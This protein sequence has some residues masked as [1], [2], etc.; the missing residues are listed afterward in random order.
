MKYLNNTLRHEFKYIIH[1]R[2]YV[3]LK[4]RLSTMMHPDENSGEEG[5]HIRS[6]Y[7]DDI[8]HTAYFEKLSGVQYRQKYRVRIYNLSDE[9]IKLERKEKF[10]DFI[11]K[12]SINLSKE[13]FYWLI[14]KENLEFLLQK[15]SDMAKDMFW[16][17][18]TKLLAPAVIVD[19]VREVYVMDEGNVRITFDQHLQAGIDTSN[20][21]DRNVTLINVLEPNTMV[22][23]VKYD[24]Y[25][26]AFIQAAIQ[27]PV[28]RREAVSKYIYCRYA[29]FQ[30]NPA[31]QYLALGESVL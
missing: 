18:R 2:E 8:Y 29:Q 16:D 19:Y 26:P 9:N 4:A 28:H 21:F 10:G 30:R 27:I 23:E 11:S 24:D 13:E 20:I 12:K 31:M 5:Y 14:H 25:L 22:L 7:F 6:L 15:N 1:E 3:G 17:M